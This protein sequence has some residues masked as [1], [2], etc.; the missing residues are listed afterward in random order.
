MIIVPSIAVDASCRGNPGPMEYK[1]V[2]T[3][4]KKV[5]FQKK[6][7]EGTNNMGEFLAIVHAAAWLKREGILLPIYSDSEI[8]IRW[9]K[10][11]ECNTTIRIS[12]KNMEAMILVK[13]A[14]KWLRSNK[15]ET[16][17]LKWDTLNCGEIP[18]D[19]GRKK[20]YSKG[21]T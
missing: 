20:L 19:F 10:N 1:G 3:D 17:V 6:F 15:L 5:I 4:T 7:E 18:A 13:R 11:K 8:A 14:V 12:K 2:Y 16:D 9:V 21:R